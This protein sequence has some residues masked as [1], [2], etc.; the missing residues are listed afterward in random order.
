MTVTYAE[1][2]SVALKRL[3]E[4]TRNTAVFPNCNRLWGLF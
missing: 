2:T 3:N 1:T 4:Q